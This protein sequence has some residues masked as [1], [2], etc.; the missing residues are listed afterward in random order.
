MSS[1]EELVTGLF[2]L[3]HK[4]RNTKRKGWYDKNIKRDRVE[5]VADHIYG[6][7]MLAYAMKSEFDYDVDIEKVILMLAVHEIG[8]TIIVDLTPED[9]SS[10]EKSKI[11]RKA[12]S[13]LLDLIPNTNMLR[14]LFEE[15][16][17]CETKEAKFAYQIDKAECDLQARLYEQDG[18]FDENYERY[19]FTKGW[20][21][22]DR[23]KINFDE[24]FDKLLSFII[25][26]DMC[27]KKCSDN[28]IQN[29]ISFYTSTNSLKNI[30]RTGEKI[31]GINPEH[32]GSIAE[33]IYSTQMLAIAIYLVYGVNINI[34]NVIN[35]LSIHELGEV[36]IGDKSALLKSK[37]DRDDEWNGAIE[38]SSFL[39]YGDIIL[40]KL[41]EFNDGKTVDATYAKYCDKLAPDMISK[42]YD[43]LNL[44]DLNNQ[45]NN[46]LL[47]NPIVKRYLETGKSFSEMWILY[48]QEVYKYPEPFISISNYVLNSDVE[49]PYTRIIK[50]AN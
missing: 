5:S 23:S 18:S 9:M 2:A 3:M 6:C 21:G 45:G 7:Q 1:N 12:V 49:E 29:V 48:G 43:Q 47:N 34:T 27:V 26:N 11:E 39:I 15:F 10:Q 33:H 19:S 40:S 24:N 4:L 16:E 35:M 14:D 13:D 38:I 37:D 42:I 25:S 44:I 20:V 41:A 30:Q 36:V 46:P 50:R 8:K 22:F 17:A 31:W 32:F 28:K